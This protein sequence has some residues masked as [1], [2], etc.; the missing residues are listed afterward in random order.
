MKLNIIFNRD[1]TNN[2]GINGEL[3]Y[4]IKEDLQWFKSITS[5]G[6]VVMGYN[7]WKSLPVKPLKDRINVV[8][9]KNNFYYLTSTEGIKKPQLIFKS[10]EEFT[11]SF[12]NEDNKEIFII[13]GS[14]LYEEAFNYGVDTIYETICD[15]IYDS[16]KCVKSNISI[17]Y[18]HT[19]YMKTFCKESSGE[20]LIYNNGKERVKEVINYKFNI[21]QRIEDVNL[22]EFEY[23][24]LLNDV[25]LNGTKRPTRNSEVISSFGEKMKFDL[26]KGF[27]LLTTKR[28]G[29]KTV[30]R[31]LLWF[32]SGS[33]DNK[34]LQEKNVH[35]WDGNSS[36]EY[37]ESRG[38]DYEEGDLGPIYGFQWRNFGGGYNISGEA[39]KGIDQLKYMLDLIKNDPTSRRII[40]SAWNPPDLDKMALP[41]C[42][43]LFQIYVDGEYIDGQMYQ[44]SGDMFLGVPFNIASYSF[45]LHIFGKITDKTPR[46]LHHIIGDCHIYSNHYNEVE[47]QLK[48]KTFAFPKLEIN[49][50]I[51]DID[52]IDENVFNIV[53]Y[54]YHP[55]I[56][57]EMVA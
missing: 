2:I 6:V 25:Y 49:G 40:M 50:D 42:H 9:T 57:A 54:K 33:T 36:K 20:A 3:I 5:G 17:G 22:G 39:G 19:D 21:Y 34:V 47:T 31:E 16:D 12:L 41:P 10:F 15:Y 44:R 45:L 29:W 4:H 26:R 46:Y 52:N 13:G 14:G 32:I 1:K 30:L 37:M 53:D 38:L 11:S 55:S 23:L 7:T 8:I 18:C 35:I 48:R 24:K 56:K 51:N 28:M 27:P 43:I